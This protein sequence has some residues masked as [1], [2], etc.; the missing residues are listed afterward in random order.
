MPMV[1]A[2]VTSKKLHGF[3]CRCLYCG[4]VIPGY[5]ESQVKYNMKLHVEAKHPAESGK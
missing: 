4:L 1:E 3:S 2:T 5:S